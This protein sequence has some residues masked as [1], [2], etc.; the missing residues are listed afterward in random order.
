MIKLYLQKLQLKKMNK[1]KIANT[2]VG[3]NYPPY[4]IAELSA[5]HNGS[6]ERALKTIYAAKKAGANAVKLQTYTADSMTINSNKDDFR[7]KTGLWKNKKLYDLYKDASTPYEW[8]EKL[9]LYAKK[10]GITCFSTPFDEAAADFLKKLKV[11][12]YK[13]ASFEL[14]DLE[15]IKHV[16][17][18]NKPIIL[19]TGM[20]N[21][22]QISNAIKT[23][24]KT[25][26]KKIVLLHCVSGYPAPNK[27]FN[28]STIQ[29]LKKKF[30]VIVGLS[31]HSKTSIAANAAV[32]LGASVIE[33][34]VKL[35][36]DEN[37]YDSK[38]S[39]TPN[40][41]KELCQQTYSTWETIG[42][43]NYKLKK[44]EKE[45]IKFKRS[46]Y[47]VKD[48]KKNQIITK[49]NVRKIRP[50]YGLDPSYYKKIVG[51]YVNRNISRGTPVK[52]KYLYDK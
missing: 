36:N 43:I 28:L 30:N 9:M 34:H 39:I 19:S 48:L 32:S 24:K 35:D 44:S 50:G 45:S 18:N 20:S 6:I 10:I 1:I 37:G 41:L 13:I 15:L 5:N 4:I 23:V 29:D 51:S 52:K 12:A 2:Y 47:F 21:L 3:N 33:K 42:K 17:K 8:H 22:D 46:L 40:E 38:F 31:D 25:G 16:S 26:L 49:D 11:P 14:N 27:D 7:I